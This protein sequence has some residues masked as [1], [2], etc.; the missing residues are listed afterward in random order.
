MS[1]ERP[2]SFAR[3][4][5]AP[6]RGFFGGVGLVFR[7]FRLWATSPRLMLLGALPALLVGV[8]YLGLI[9]AL[10]LNLG[11]LAGWVTP[12]ADAWLTGWQLALRI[13]VALAMLGLAALLLVATYTAVTLA[14][15]DPF[16]E[17]ISREV[18]T[19]LGGMPESAGRFWRSFAR[20]LGN[21]VRLILL[22]VAAA[23]L[24]LVVG[25]I[26][27]VGTVGAFVLAAGFGGWILAIEL[28]G[29]VFDARGLKLR[30]R[31]R[32]L[33]ARRATTL[34]FGMA[35]Y[36][37]LLVPF[38]AVVV[39]PAAVAGATLLGR[40]ALAAATTERS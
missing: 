40:T 1:D 29:F 5:A 32:M 30:Q 8:V 20:G 22:A 26:P 11:S 12:F 15:G 17:R 37:L 13:V 2:T 18:E 21:T 33:A 35:V 27:V 39:M 25:F 36:L 23:L 7:G 9:V 28:T 4:A 31:R 24:V 3:A 10:A 6:A 14:V 38:A 16:Y 34:G 19:T